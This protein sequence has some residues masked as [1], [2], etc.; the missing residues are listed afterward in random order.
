MHTEARGVETFD[1]P[2]AQHTRAFGIND[3][4]EIVGEY[5][6]SN[7]RTHGFIGTFQ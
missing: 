2:G 4:G 7:G 6:D 1:F 3:V 5:V